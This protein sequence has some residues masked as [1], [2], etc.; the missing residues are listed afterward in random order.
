MN[1]ARSARFAALLLAASL[2]IPSHAGPSED[3]DAAYKN[4]DYATALHLWRDLADQGDAKAQAGLGN[5][6][7]TGRGGLP[8]DD[9]Q[10]LEWFRKAADQGNAVGQAGLGFMYFN[11]RGGLS[12][13]EVEA[14]EWYRKAAKQ[15]NAVGQRNLG[16]MYEAGRGVAK[17]GGSGLAQRMR[18]LEREAAKPDRR[19][20]AV[21]FARGLVS[22]GG[23]TSEPRAR[24]CAQADT[25]SD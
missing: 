10:A 21:E 22:K 23:R 9:K 24:A 8:Q 18:Q 17:D 14:V 12:K 16:Y 6:Y 1:L 13:D 5:M 15:A 4:G 25:L 11:G 2:S 3:A 19:P 20:E 7:A